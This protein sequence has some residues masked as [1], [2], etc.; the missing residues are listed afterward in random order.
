M[1]VDRHGSLLLPGQDYKKAMNT[2][3]VLSCFPPTLRYNIFF[4]SW[5]LRR[6]TDYFL[7][8]ANSALNLIRGTEKERSHT[9]EDAN[10]TDRVLPE[11]V[12]KICAH[13]KH[14]RIRHI[15]PS[16]IDIV[17][18]TQAPP[19][20]SESSPL[21]YHWAQNR[22]PALCKKTGPKVWDRRQQETEGYVRS[23]ERVFVLQQGRHHRE[24]D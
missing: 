13:S 9:D 19:T 22:T 14:P 5:G 6:P 7:L 3:Q 20:R 18:K 17:R 10:I 11:N 23:G 21:T 24:K 8:P 4:H 12:V 1:G 2:A 15:Y 16:V